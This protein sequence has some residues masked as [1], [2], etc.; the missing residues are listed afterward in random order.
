MMTAFRSTFNSGCIQGVPLG[1]VGT[2]TLHSPKMKSISCSRQSHTPSP[3][4]FCQSD[5][6]LEVSWGT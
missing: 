1:S 6:V 5:L 2:S 3:G 4:S